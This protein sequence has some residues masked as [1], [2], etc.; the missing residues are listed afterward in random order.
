MN[1]YSTKNILCEQTIYIR[2]RGLSSEKLI[3][4]CGISVLKRIYQT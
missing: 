3:K 2:Q 1:S 4:L